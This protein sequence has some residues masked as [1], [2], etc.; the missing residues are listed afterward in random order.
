MDMPLWTLTMAL[1]WFIWR[2]KDAVIETIDEYRQNWREW[3]VVQGDSENLDDLV[4]A[5][6]PVGKI[7]VADLLRHPDIARLP[8]DELFD[9]SLFDPARPFFAGSSSPYQRLVNALHLG[10]HASAISSKSE[11]QSHQRVPYPLMVSDLRSSLHSIRKKLPPG[12]DPRYAVKL[13]R[14]TNPAEHSDA[15]FDPRVPHA[16]VISAEILASRLD[17]N[18]HSWT[19]EYVLGWIAYREIDK[20]RLL[21]LPNLGAAASAAAER[22]LGVRHIHPEAELLNALRQGTLIAR[23]SIEVMHLGYPNP[24]PGEWWKDRT[25]SDAPHLRFV[26]DE[27]IKLW[28]ADGT[29]SS[30][31]ARDRSTADIASASAATIDSWEPSTKLTVGERKVIIEA[32]RHWPDC[33]C[34]LR[35]QEVYKKIMKDWDR[36]QL[37]VSLGPRTII[38]ALKKIPAW[39]AWREANLG[40]Q[41]RVHPA[42]DKTLE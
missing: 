27:V 28:T 14:R 9:P 25:L 40:R 32:K 10:L 20:F 15:Y 11:G 6:Q 38:R 35:A 8:T 39:N 1:A 17:Y 30:S 37:G 4:W 29:T 31:V 18:W 19:T 23:P 3:T 24:I 5:L 12:S 22:R 34:L 7:S 2:T 36:D 21:S 42:V 41:N 13:P 33:K 16:E 26:K